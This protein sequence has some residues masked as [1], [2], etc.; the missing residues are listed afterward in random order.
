MKKL[1]DFME[2]LQNTT[3]I[4][5]T[6]RIN[7]ERGVRNASIQMLDL[8]V[9]DKPFEN[10]SLSEFEV[11]LFLTL[12]NDSFKKKD[13]VGHRMYSRGLKQYRSFLK[14]T[15]N[16]NA[17]QIIN[18]IQKAN[19]QTTQKEAII[20]AR[21]G[22]GKFR[23]NLLNKY[24]SCIISGIKDARLLIASHIKPWSVCENNDRLDTE[25][26]LLL[27]SLYDKMFDLGLISFKDSGNIMVSPSLKKCDLNIFSFDLDKNYDLKS[28]EQLLSNL[29]YHR[30]YVFLK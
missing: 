28:S 5:P 7:Y 3:D 29:E 10:M 4:T 27:N 16:D 15:N 13:S 25:N 2:Y 18:A 11:A 9:I 8:K 19:I 1:T 6:T 22:Q 20:K 23:K 14:A 30:D 17:E 12:N 24:E 21:I 26:G